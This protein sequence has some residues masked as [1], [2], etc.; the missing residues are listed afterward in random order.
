[1]GLDIRLPIGLMFSLVGLLLVASGLISSDPET[2]RRSL[3]V[4]INLYWGLFLVVF[5]GLMLFFALKSA[6]AE[7]NKSGKPGA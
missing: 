1:M 5:G 3:G 6:K 4:N 2:L 7:K